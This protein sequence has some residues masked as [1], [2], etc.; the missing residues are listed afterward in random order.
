MTGDALEYE[1]S[2][3]YVE[4]TKDSLLGAHGYWMRGTLEAG[5]YGGRGIG[6]ALK[7]TVGQR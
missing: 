7:R 5:P 4:N 2:C 1:T 3:I 6:G